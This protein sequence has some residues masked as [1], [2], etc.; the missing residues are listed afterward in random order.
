ML[1]DVVTTALGLVV[2]VLTGYYFEWRSSR[3]TRAQNIELE[4]KLRVL[5]ESIYSV[6]ARDPADSI[7]SS[8]SVPKDLEQQLWQWLQDFQGPD[9]TI[10]RTRVFD[11]FSGLGYN[12]NE[13]MAALTR[14]DEQGYVD[15]GEEIRV[16]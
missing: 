6:N 4:N 11:R 3:S 1:N 10:Q 9:G 8:V 12:A 13:V 7:D 2:G 14:L 5:R 16:Q 15:M